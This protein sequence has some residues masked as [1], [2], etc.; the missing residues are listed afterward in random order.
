MSKAIA[1]TNG[2]K[3][4]R[5]SEPLGW[6]SLVCPRFYRIYHQK[7]GDIPCARICHKSRDTDAPKINHQMIADLTLCVILPPLIDKP[8]HFCYTLSTW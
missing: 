1:K 3:G 4:F 6:L 2:H 5:A 7:F 8:Y